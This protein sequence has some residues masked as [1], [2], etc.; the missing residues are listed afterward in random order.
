MVTTPTPND[1]VVLSVTIEAPVAGLIQVTTS[2]QVDD[3]V[4][5][6]AGGNYT[7]KLTEGVGNVAGSGTLGLADRVAVVNFTEPA[8]CSTNGALVV[9]KGTYV[10]NL[11]LGTTAN[12]ANRYEEATL[13]AIFV[14]G[15]ST[16]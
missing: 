9:T 12:V 3:G 13:D 4:G 6:G 5:D 11:V 16:T 8:S 14:A 1:S 15:G 7:C 2:A 10:I